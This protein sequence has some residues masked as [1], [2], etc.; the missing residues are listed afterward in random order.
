MIRFK[1]WFIERIFEPFVD[2]IRRWWKLATAPILWDEYEPAWRT[3]LQRVLLWLP[4]VVLIAVLAGGTSLYLFLG[5][6]A[7]DL[8]GKALENARSGNLSMAWLQIRSAENMRSNLTEVQRAK[9]FVLSR[10]GTGASLLLWEKLA[11]KGKLSPEESEE[12]ARLAMMMGTE[13]Q[14]EAAVM[15]LEQN[16][17]S[18]A[19]S[20]FRSKRLL[21]SG[22][23]S[24]A[25]NQARE[26]AVSGDPSRQVNLLRTLL[27][28]YRPI[29]KKRGGTAPGSAEAAREIIALVDQLQGTPRGNQAIAMALENFFPPA[30]KIREWSAAAW[31]DLSPSNTALLPATHAMIAFHEGTP[32]DFFEKLS[33][34]FENADLDQQ[35][36]FAQWLSRYQMWDEILE[37]ITPEK[38]ERKAAAFQQRGQALAG[39][40]RWQD[41]VTMTGASPQIYSSL[42]STLRGLALKRLNK[43]SLA[44]NA[45]ADAVYAAAKEGTLESTLKT[46]DAMGEGSVADPI[47]IKLCMD[48]LTV[49]VAFRAAND[50]FSRR[51]QLASLTEAWAAAAATAPEL[52]AILDYKRRVDL[53]EGREVPLEITAAAEVAA[54]TDVQVRFTHALNLLKAGHAAEAFGVINGK[55]TFAEELP[56]GDKAVAIAI[57]K[58]NGML[59]QASLLRRSLDPHLLRKGE[60]A[61]LIP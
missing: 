40:G 36:S 7:M 24:A 16:G 37:L 58:A 60:F 48:P 55:D 21:R 10:I 15:T 61:L 56:P 29:L 44:R 41:L 31:K 23:V 11:A 19:A 27:L 49:D 50:R 45:L 33:P 54:P 51:G 3:I 57:L 20:G 12:W 1:E 5:W 26:A 14:F 52:P 39:K 22:D 6:R 43:P 8:A 34:V 4:P 32:R 38:A 18:E 17:N 47:L 30:D 53:L 35:I 13:A 59:T 28:H 9:A 2:L 46:L 42:R 25:I